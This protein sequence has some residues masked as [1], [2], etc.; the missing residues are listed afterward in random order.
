MPRPA[1]SVSRV[2]A[3]LGLLGSEPI[4]FLTMSEIA[5]RLDLNKA[6]AHGILTVLAEEGYVLR[7]PEDKGYALGPAVTTVGRAAVADEYAIVRA[8]RLEMEELAETGRCQCVANV[9]CGEQIQVIG[10]TGTPSGSA[11]THLG[12]RGPFLPPL[13]VVFA[14]WADARRREGWIAGQSLSEA[15][16]DAIRDGLAVVRDRGFSVTPVTEHRAEFEE[17]AE[18]LL[19][20]VSN[21]AVRRAIAELAAQIARE[22]GELTDIRGDQRYL[23]RQISAPVF[24]A[25]GAVKIALALSG[26]PEVNG[27]RL[28]DLGYAVVAAAARISRSVGAPPAPPATP[29]DRPLA[30]AAG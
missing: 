20:R 16:A 22:G 9:L 26:L 15:E 27:A 29:D 25:D 12:S 10:S 17:L 14:A 5:R 2:I 19:A 11:G 6:T 18:S 1:P 23:V 7:D 8:A 13:G 21:D 3:V 28:R 30:A 24:G 4:D